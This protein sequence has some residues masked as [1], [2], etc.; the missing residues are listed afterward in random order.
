MIRE[1]GQGSR[2]PEKAYQRSVS[3]IVTYKLKPP[4]ISPGDERVHKKNKK[5]QK[6]GQRQP[7]YIAWYAVS[8]E[9]ARALEDVE[10]R[11]EALAGCTM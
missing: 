10:L 4:G 8:T 1:G 5:E 3:T 7:C 2:E 9:Y 11:T 6:N